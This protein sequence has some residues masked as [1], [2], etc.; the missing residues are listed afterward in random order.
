[1][2]RTIRQVLSLS[3]RHY[4]LAKLAQQR[5]VSMNK[6]LDIVFMLASNSYMLSRIN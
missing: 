1:M 3:E 6:A 5:H 2:I 4:F